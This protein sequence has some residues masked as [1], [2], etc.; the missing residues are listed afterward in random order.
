MGYQK[1]LPGAAYPPEGF[2][3]V[4]LFED[5]GG[6]CIDAYQLI[7]IKS[8]SGS[9]NDRGML[10]DIR[11]GDVIL[12][13][14]GFWHSYAPDPSVGW[15]EYY[16]GFTGK[17]FASQIRELYSPNDI[18]LFSA[19]EIANIADMFECALKVTAEDGKDSRIMADSF[20]CMLIA[21]LRHGNKDNKDTSFVAAA[22]KYMEDNIASKI[23]S[24]DIAK[25]LG[26][27]NAWFRKEFTAQTGVSPMT[28]LM[29]VRLQKAK[30]LLLAGND[31]VKSIAYRCGFS[32]TEYFCNFFYKNTGVTP[33]Q[34][35]KGTVGGASQV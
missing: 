32:T 1:I 26:V 23:K 20:A 11:Q 12:V 3:D 35:R 28:F 10:Y 21:Q 29:I 13:Q 5:N 7:Y 30:Y 24:E 34:F 9:F 2:P 16:I 6:R 4:C 33:T 17:V 27:S 19:R 18:N 14:P 31:S 22:R 15:E 8:G 25:Y